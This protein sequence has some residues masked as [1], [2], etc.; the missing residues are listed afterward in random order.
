MLYML[1]D[2]AVLSGNP[3]LASVTVQGHAKALYA[4]LGREAAA[5][6]PWLIPLQGEALEWLK[7]LQADETV[8]HAVSVLTVPGDIGV[9]FDVERHLHV[10][11]HVHT[12][13]E[14]RQRY[15]FRYAD[16]R[17]LSR[18]WQVLTAVQ[19]VALLGPVQI[20]QWHAQGEQ[21]SVLTAPPHK[22]ASLASLPLRLDPQQ[23]KQVLDATRAD[24]L[25][26]S[27]HEWFPDYIARVPMPLQRE[28]AR[29]AQ[30]WLRAQGV[31]DAAIELAVAAIVIGQGQQV[32]HGS[33]FTAIVERAVA[34]HDPSAVLDWHAGDVAAAAPE[35]RSVK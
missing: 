32:L 1:L 23:F 27:T 15:F 4:D 35:T 33:S 17:A 21:P 16:T 29:H 2:G 7:H 5:I 26:A 13:Q 31:V 34:D 3:I 18:V 11:R 20:W 6:G 22:G 14:G 9:K 24:E 8:S 12:R 19:Q 28:R 30:A 10:L 25:L